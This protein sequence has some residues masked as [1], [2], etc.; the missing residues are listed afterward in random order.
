MF[1]TSPV[2]SAASCFSLDVSWDV[3]LHQSNSP[4]QVALQQLSCHVAI[5]SG[6]QLLQNVPWSALNLLSSECSW[7]VPLVSGIVPGLEG[8]FPLEPCH[9]ITSLPAICGSQ[10]M[11]L[12]YFMEHFN[13]DFFQEHYL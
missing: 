3:P 6:I 4:Q 12:A 7:Q 13:P 11:Y 1:L 10:Q 8:M 5:Y 9:D 2:L